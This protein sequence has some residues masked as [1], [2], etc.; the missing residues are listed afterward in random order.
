MN[1]YYKIL[2]LLFVT[3]T[4]L[5]AN[6][7]EKS[8]MTFNICGKDIKSKVKTIE[9]KN[10][11]SAESFVKLI[12]KNAK[13]NPLDNTMIFKNFQ[14][15]VLPGSF[16][17]YYSDNNDFNVIQMPLPV[18]AIDKVIYLPAGCINDALK[19]LNIAVRR[20]DAIEDLKNIHHAATDETDIGESDI[21]WDTLNLK[22]NKVTDNKELAKQFNVIG[23][24]VL[25]SYATNGTTNNKAK[26]SELNKEKQKKNT[27]AEY[28][29]PPNVYVLPKGLI[30][31]NI[32]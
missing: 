20:D 14:L 19:H 18:I 7:N 24:L 17:V 12:E 26:S 16:F 32:K 27:S 13:F 25:Q 31:P 3:I 4:V 28:A 15:K 1:I 2:L 8:T 23:N 30:R 9:D 10:Y 11:I 22:N 21:L 6:S 5:Q 29:F